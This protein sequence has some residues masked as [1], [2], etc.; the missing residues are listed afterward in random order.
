MKVYVISHINFLDTY[1]YGVVENEEIAKEV[2][3]RLGNDFTYEKFDT[4]NVLMDDEY[5]FRIR[6]DR[7]LIEEIFLDRFVNEYTFCHYEK[8][9]DK[10]YCHKSDWVFSC[11]IKAKSEELA[12][13]VAYDMGAE[14][15]AKKKGVL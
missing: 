6:F 4:E 1:V 3:K 13:K 2:V 11:Y 12:K 9:N 5:W 7:N 15:L 10:C 8:I 14:Y